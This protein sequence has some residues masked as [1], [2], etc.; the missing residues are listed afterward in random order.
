MEAP[1]ASRSGTITK[2][3]GTAAKRCREVGGRKTVAP[4]RARAAAS[5]TVITTRSPTLSSM[6]RATIRPWGSSTK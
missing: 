6:M 3:M 2:A 4:S 1:E 5:A